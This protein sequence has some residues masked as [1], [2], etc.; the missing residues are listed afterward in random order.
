MPSSIR[1]KGTAQASFPVEGMF[2]ILVAGGYG[3]CNMALNTSDLKISDSRGWGEGTD[4]LLLGPHF[5]PESLR[6]R[7]QLGH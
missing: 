7:R 5:N 2:S 4:R 3:C 1:E 6:L